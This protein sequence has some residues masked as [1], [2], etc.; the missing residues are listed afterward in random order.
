MEM[1]KY[2]DPSRL[3]QDGDPHLTQWRYRFVPTGQLRYLNLRCD[4]GLEC[5]LY[6]Q[7]LISDE[8]EAR[9]LA[10]AAS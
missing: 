8:V 9:E 3:F 1:P 2:K 6:Y 5:L 4:S 7:C 10:M